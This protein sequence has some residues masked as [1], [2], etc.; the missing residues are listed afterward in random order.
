MSDQHP[1]LQYILSLA[2]KSTWQRSVE[3]ADAAAPAWARAIADREPKRIYMVGCGTSYY[4]AQVAKR[5]FEQLAHVPADPQQAFA[6]ATYTEPALLGPD[7]PVIAISTSGESDAVVRAL[8]RARAA[9]A[10]TVAVTAYEG[11]TVGN[12]ADAVILTGGDGDKANCKTS[13]YV[14]SLITPY[15]MALALGVERGVIPA[16]AAGYWRGQID[17]AARG[18]AA[19]LA[20][21]S[22][23]SAGGLR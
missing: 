19:F 16:D 9:G 21:R 4:A 2:E 13:S 3:L 17:T 22:H 15:L 23:Q 18:A 5:F 20:Q 6:F 14:Q 8:A 10:P 1:V 11:T 7:T 12:A